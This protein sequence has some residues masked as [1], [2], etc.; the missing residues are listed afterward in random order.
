LVF[1]FQETA[2]HANKL[3]L[4]SIEITNLLVEVE[5]LGEL[6]EVQQAMSKTEEV[7]KLKERKSNYI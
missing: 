1:I 3:S 7:D 4:L 6:G 5:R 2:E